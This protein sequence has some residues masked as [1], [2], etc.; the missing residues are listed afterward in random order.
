MQLVL[1]CVFPLL[2]VLAA[3][4][5]PRLMRHEAEAK[6]HR[7][8]TE[9]VEI[10]A[11]RE[12]AAAST[13]DLEHGLR[14]TAQRAQGTLATDEAVRLLASGGVPPGG[15]AI[16]I[17]TR[18]KAAERAAYMKKLLEPL[19][20]DMDVLIGTEYNAT[21][22][23]LR[24]ACAIEAYPDALNPGIQAI[25]ASQKRALKMAL[26][27]KE[28]WTLIF[29]DDIELLPVPTSQW[30]EA[31]NKAWGRLKYRDV[32]VVRLGWCAFT[33][34]QPTDPE[35]LGNGFELWRKQK[36]T[37]IHDPEAPWG[38]NNGACTTANIFNK[39]YVKE[40]LGEFFK[41]HE[42][43]DLFYAHN[44]FNKPPFSDKVYAITHRDSAQMFKGWTT[45]PQMGLVAQK[46]VAMNQSQS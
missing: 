5:P 20:T 15:H 19:G 42:P 33:K 37:N 30:L 34:T 31:F 10:A 45:F 44:F 23:E 28:N 25:A 35:D 14:Y 22:E 6:P 13:S 38:I 21:Q 12:S 9:A 3:D 46:H 4:E 24:S 27:R 41:C 17:T 16:M 40:I 7:V 2:V 36:T 18:D 29:E 26:A 11:A 32:A 43:V 1:S 8:T 39:E